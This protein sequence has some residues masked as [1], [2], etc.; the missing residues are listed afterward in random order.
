MSWLGENVELIPET[1]HF[2][3]KIGN[4]KHSRG[5]HVVAEFRH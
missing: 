1:R 4:S 5:Q 2:T 3:M